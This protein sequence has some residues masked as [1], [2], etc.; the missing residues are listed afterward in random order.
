[1]CFLLD[2]STL[3]RWASFNKMI[4]PKLPYN[5]LTIDFQCP[6]NILIILRLYYIRD[7]LDDPLFT[8]SHKLR[9]D[10]T[11]DKLKEKISRIRDFIF[12]EVFSWN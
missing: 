11:D 4:S 2:E 8:K 12:E 9:N 5:L 6:G 3:Y 10:N 1:M 7:L